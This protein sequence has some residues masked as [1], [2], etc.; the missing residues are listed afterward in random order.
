MYTTMDDWG[1]G[2]VRGSFRYG[3]ER[4]ARPIISLPKLTPKK[5]ASGDLYSDYLSL[6]YE[7]QRRLAAYQQTLEEVQ[8]RAATVKRIRRIA[9]IMIAATKS[10]TTS[11]QRK[12]L[13]YKRRLK[14]GLLALRANQYRIAAAS[15]V[16][17]IGL[18]TLATPLLQAYI[19]KP[20]HLSN[21]VQKLVG[22]TRDDTKQYLSYDQTNGAY[23][24]AVPKAQNSEESTHTGRI[25]TAYESTFPAKASDGVSVTDTDTNINIKLRPNF[26]T[27]R[28]SKSDGDHIVYKSGN[29]QLIYS[30]KYNGLKEDIIVPSFQ[31][32][33]MS[34]QFQLELPVGVEARLDE[35]GN[36]GIFSADPTLFG[37]I[38]YGSDTDRAKVEKARQN[39]EKNNLIMT[40][41]Y[42]IVK[43][44][45][46]K[47]YSNKASFRL[48]ARQTAQTADTS[49]KGLPSDS[50]PQLATVNHYSL[51]LDAHDLRDLA[52]PISLDPTIQ[53]KNSAD[54]TKVNMDGSASIDTTNNLIK[55]ASLT[56]GAIN[57]W[58]QNPNN[59]TSIPGGN[60]GGDF[61]VYNGYLYYIRVNSAVQYAPI[62][63]DGS[64]G[65]FTSTGVTPPSASYDSSVIYNGYFYTSG[66]NQF[67]YS[68]I[69]NNGTIGSF[70]STN[71]FSTPG[72]N[73][74]GSFS[75]TVGNG[76]M[77]M[78]GGSYCSTTC[79]ALTETYM[80]DVQY[81]QIKADG[82]L[83][84]WG[85]A[86]GT[87]M[88][89]A[90]GLH[91]SVIYNGYYYVMGGWQGSLGSSPLDVQYAPIKTDGTLGTWQSGPAMLVG[92]TAGVTVA[93]DGYMYTIA[94]SDTN[95]TA[96]YAPIYADGSLGKWQATSSLA[97][98]RGGVA[99]ATYKDTIYIGGGSSNNGGTIWTDIQY[100]TIKPAGTVG[101]GT[102][103]TGPNSISAYGGTSLAI[104]SAIYIF[105]GCS[106][107]SCTTVLKTIRTAPI[108]SD[109]T[110]G[111]WVTNARSMV[112]PRA[113]PAV[114]YIGSKVVVA[115]GCTA[116]VLSSCNSYA[117]TVEF[118][119]AIWTGGLY[120]SGNTGT[121]AL[122]ADTLSTARS[123]AR[124]VVYNNTFYVIG[125]DTA[126]GVTSSIDY[127]HY[128]GDGTPGAW[129][130][131][132]P[133]GISDGLRNFGVG[134]WNQKIYV[135]GGS[136]TSSNYSSIRYLDISSGV[137]G[138]SWT[139]AS[140]SLS[141][142]MKYA[143]GK[144]Y[145]GYIYSVGGKNSSDTVSSNVEYFQIA[146]SGDVISR[147]GTASL[148]AARYAGG[149][150]L[151]FGKLYVAEGCTTSTLCTTPTS[152]SASQV[153]NNGGGG[154]IKS[155]TQ[156]NSPVFS[157]ARYNHRSIAYNGYLYVV[158]G[159]TAVDCTVTGKQ[160][161]DIQY[162]ALNGDGTLAGWSSLGN[163]PQSV[164]S[165]R[166][167]PG[168][169]IMNGYMYVIGGHTIL[170][171]GNNT[172]QALL[173][174]RYVAIN[175]NG[176]LGT[177]Q[178]ASATLSGT[179][180]YVSAVDYKG[181]IYFM[182][183]GYGGFGIPSTNGDVPSWTNLSNLPGTARYFAA[184][185]ISQDHIYDMSGCSTLDCVGVVHSYE[186]AS[187]GANGNTTG[188]WSEI[189]QEPD[190]VS[191]SGIAYSINGILYELNPAN[192]TVAP[193]DLTGKLSQTDLHQVLTQT[194]SSSATAYYNGRFYITGGTD[195]TTL[196]ADSF[197]GSIN[198][199]ARMGT[200]S[201][202]YDFEVGV[203]PTKLITHGIKQNGATT[204]ASYASSNDTS[205]TLDNSQQV[206]DIGY[207]GANNLSINLGTNRTLSRYFNVHYT[208]DD[209]RSA[210]YPD[211]GQESYITDFD[212]YYTPNP[213]KRLKGGRTFTNGVDRGLDAQPQ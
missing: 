117:N 11:R 13:R 131:V 133:T 129:T 199:I 43:D 36:I 106:D 107:S 136:G 121:M 81:A 110:L 100:T 62:N 67:Y 4:R 193:I 6:S 49:Q 171:D 177:W 31:S 157:T 82:S 134:Y 180:K 38:T 9:R 143:D 53:V 73:T 123:N 84:T 135:W 59:P 71:M 149:V 150:E 173:D 76:Y 194:R 189:T 142:Q 175:A 50:T 87:A 74:R 39:G 46:N 5:N 156:I 34:F 79:T 58:T 72:G 30:L 174:T 25:S 151:Y 146:S 191:Y 145:K 118:S 116:Y 10:N 197:A 86:T 130:S 144:I 196:Y 88:T 52:Y 163:V 75:V 200:F 35:N 32:P 181:K 41:P 208:I 7:Q 60:Y 27:A 186:Y 15:M 122:D 205:T 44:T 160:T 190:L 114:G 125:G 168:L 48:S 184:L 128:T 192:M 210:I 47:E 182:G 206:Q 77:Y 170:N 98:G 19:Q 94:G 195:G 183:Y 126:A 204:T 3:R 102:W 104:A 138:S 80:A 178:N 209:T 108:S 179:S 69:N 109:G 83:G 213:G 137:P 91:K 56:G 68:K 152:S 132:T 154:Q 127:S 57:G 167:A 65:S 12:I 29:R 140:S 164:G 85:S 172:L 78:S 166:V 201:K 17:V 21:G 119:S 61:Q 113:F 26:F 33:N 18:G 40:I 20:I 211:I 66:N 96:Y 185:Y 188:A 120:N 92:R 14:N 111:T 24:F 153:V 141:D 55:R 64:I 203:K 158:G 2:R 8:R 169:V 37:N 90:R 148:P 162:T 165:G 51:T 155:W 23:S 28:V 16:I 124:M 45:N 42:P 22:D 105:G 1:T 112:T 187:L 95:N 202:Q 63:S 176:T 161:A 89:N 101:D 99:G 103:D 207:S 139:T 198:S 212:L 93:L 97:S 159:C 147:T 54:F 70:T 115:G